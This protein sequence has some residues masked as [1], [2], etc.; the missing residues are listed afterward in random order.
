MGPAG[1]AH[2]RPDAGRLHSV[3]CP[4]LQLGAPRPTRCSSGAPCPVGGKAEAQVPGLWTPAL[5][6][7]GRGDW[8][9]KGPGASKLEAA[10]LPP[11]EPSFPV[12]GGPGWACKPL[13]VGWLSA[14]FRATPGPRALDSQL[15]SSSCGRGAGW[16]CR[17]C[18]WPVAKRQGPALAPG[19]PSAW[20]ICS[21]EP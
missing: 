21:V 11:A 10:L 17:G 5:G 6:E 1:R 4:G 15:G 18:E 3:P 7:W 20:S 13:A 2:S 19:C 8:R 9:P 16:S 14:L 12:L